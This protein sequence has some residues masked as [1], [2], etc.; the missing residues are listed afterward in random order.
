M[1]LWDGNNEPFITQN[2][3]ARK[4]KHKK[5]TF[6]QRSTLPKANGVQ[7]TGCSASP[8]KSYSKSGPPPPPAAA[9][10]LSAGS[11]SLNHLVEKSFSVF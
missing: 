10:L 6:Y 9:S 1:D 7:G 11:S 8:A 4:N 5:S 2:E 3:T